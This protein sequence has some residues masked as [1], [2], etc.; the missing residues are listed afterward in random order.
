MML[1]DHSPSLEG[2]HPSHLQRVVPMLQKQTIL[3]LQGCCRLTERLAQHLRLPSTS[4]N[5][6]MPQGAFDALA[7]QS[8]HRV[9]RAGRHM[10]ALVFGLHLAR[11]IDATDVAV[12]DQ[13]I[14]RDA[15][16]YGIRQAARMKDRLPQVPSPE[17]LADL[18]TATAE[19]GWRCLVR[20][21]N[22]VSEPFRAAATLRLPAKGLPIAASGAFDALIAYT[23]DILLSDD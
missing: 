6:T 7:M 1:P 13:D 3:R 17:T 20:W 8:H 12:L 22:R 9:A 19:Y 11:Q 16:L 14:G 21:R 23:I 2:L 15:R 18:R 4:L 5:P 10:G